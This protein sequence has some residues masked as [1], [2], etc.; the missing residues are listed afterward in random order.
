MKPRLAHTIVLAVVLAAAGEARA[1]D[2]ATA[3]V[4]FDQARKL[5]AQERWSEAC[6]KLEESQ[7]LD[8]A[9]GTL[10]HLALCREKEGRI[11]TAW[12]LFEDA[13]SQA[14]RD[15]RKDRAKV[16]QE[17]IETLAPKLPKMR[18]RV[19]QADRK[20][21]NFTVVRD[22]VTVGEAQWGESMPVDPGTRTIR[23]QADGRKTWVVRVEVP[24]HPQEVVVD[25]PE[26]E[27]D[28]RVAEKPAPPP[29]PS[30]PA[31][32]PIEK[33]PDDGS[34]GDTQRT[35][36]VVAIGAGVAG[37]AVGSIFGLVSINKR[38]E[39]DKNCEPPDHKL[40]NAAGID[41]GSSAVTAG[42]VSTVAF[43]VGGVLVAGGVALWF[44]APSGVAVTPT[45]GPNGGG[46]ALSAKFR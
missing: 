46:V 23:A 1:A 7:R 20:L 21:P 3:Q 32:Q 28:P 2:P 43:I 4:L 34:R 45:A 41:A 18:V 38:N 33:T 10:L 36:A 6:P 13:L 35:L 5:M 30:L 22:D 31:Q 15:G 14:K 16:A 12:A 9:G 40:C 27:A 44:T 24:P 11:A 37:A 17:H 42:N 29:P 19:A 25:V 26:L 8:P 39:A